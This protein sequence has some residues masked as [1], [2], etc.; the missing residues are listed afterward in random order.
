[1]IDEKRKVFV[2]TKEQVS[3]AKKRS[4]GYKEVSKGQWIK[5]I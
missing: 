1:M 2:M 4:K 5:T 3:H